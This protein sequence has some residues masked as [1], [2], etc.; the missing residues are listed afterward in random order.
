[1]ASLKTYKTIS[2]EKY[3]AVAEAE[4]ILASGVSAPQVGAGSLVSA[5]AY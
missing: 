2:N 3:D 1:M 5:L 4:A